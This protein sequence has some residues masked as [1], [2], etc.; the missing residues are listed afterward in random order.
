MKKLVIL[1]GL[2][3]MAQSAFAGGTMLMLDSDI[4]AGYNYNYNNNNVQEQ[5]QPMQLDPN[6][7]Y[8]TKD[9]IYSPNNGLAQGLTRKTYKTR[10]VRIGRQN[11]N[12][13]NVY[14]NFGRVN[15]GSGFTSVG[16]GDK[17]Y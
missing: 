6:S 1:L 10:K 4:P 14:W 16:S 2:M 8:F 11:Y 15:F 5:Q 9:G 12:D 17:K 3:F 13:P 7:T